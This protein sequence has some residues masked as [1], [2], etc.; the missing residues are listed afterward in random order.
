MDT[1][2]KTIIL[3]P[4]EELSQPFSSQQFQ[5]FSTFPLRNTIPHSISLIVS[6]IKILKCLSHPLF[7]LFA[8]SIT[9]FESGQGQ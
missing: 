1:L 6:L 2:L 7:C 9:D 4:H 8:K 5:V 3:K